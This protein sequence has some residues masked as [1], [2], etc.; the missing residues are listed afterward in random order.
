MEDIYQEAKECPYEDS[1]R[2][3]LEG[4]HEGLTVPEIE[5]K[6]FRRHKAKLSVQ[7]GNGMIRLT[8]RI[9]EEFKRFKL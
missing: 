9:G 4:L 6:T 2:I 1:K 5:K 3:F 7:R 8:V